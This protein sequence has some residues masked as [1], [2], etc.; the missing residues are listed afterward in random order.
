MADT[1]RFDLLESILN[2]LADG[3]VVTDPHGRLVLENAAAAWM[4]K[5]CLDG[6]HGEV[7][8]GD[9]VTPVPASELPVNRALRGEAVENLEVLV[10]EH[11]G[12][13]RW[14]LVTA[15]PLTGAGGANLGAVAVCK[16]ISARKRIELELTENERRYRAIFNSTFECVGLLSPDGTLLEANQTALDLIWAN[17][18]EVQGRKFWDTPWWQHSEVAAEQIR[19]AIARGAGGQT[20]RREVDHIDREGV[21]RR[22]DFCIQPIHNEAG[23][24]VSLLAEARDITLLEARRRY[25]VLLESAPDA[26]LEVGPGG[27]GAGVGDGQ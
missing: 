17:H 15:R 9:G 23:A 4:R 26:I 3:V 19:D 14:V 24:V 22:F 13:E 5:A 2:S 16:D 6:V 27:S 8:G 10:R 25:E 11:D 20:F 18:S 12:P 21:T 7:L 1:S